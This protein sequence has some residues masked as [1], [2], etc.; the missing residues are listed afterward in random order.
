MAGDRGEES[1][2]A[3]V[4]DLRTSVPGADLQ[5]RKEDLPQRAVIWLVAVCRRRWS[6]CPTIRKKSAKSSG[7]GKEEERNDP[8]RASWS[9]RFHRKFMDESAMFISSF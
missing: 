8:S 1:A 9:E 6:V 7:E 3:T 4:A 5:L 2:N